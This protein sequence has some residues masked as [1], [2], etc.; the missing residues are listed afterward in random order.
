MRKLPRSIGTFLFMVVL[1]AAGPSFGVNDCGWTDYFA[2][3]AVKAPNL[4]VRVRCR[5][6]AD[7]AALQF[8]NVGRQGIHFVWEGRFFGPQQGSLNPGQTGQAIDHA[9]KFW[10]GCSCGDPHRV[11]ITIVSAN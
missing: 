4:Q 9:E 7:Y 2:P 11:T 5:P 10:G 3:D 8:R 6:V 1:F